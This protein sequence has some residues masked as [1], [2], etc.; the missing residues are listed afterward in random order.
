MSSKGPVGQ[1]VKLRGGCLPP[2]GRLTTGL[3]VGNL[4]HKSAN[5]HSSPKR[6]STPPQRRAANQVRVVID[7]K[8]TERSITH[9]KTL[10][11]IVLLL[12]LLAVSGFAQPTVTQ[13]QNAA[14]NALAPLP[15]SAIGQGSYFS[16]YGTGI[17]PSTIAYWNP[18]PLPTSLGELPL[19]SRLGQMPRSRLI[20]NSFRPVRSTRYC[21]QAPLRARV[22]S[23]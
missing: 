11:A 5:R 4:P 10:F 8:P 1:L 7:L 3:Q 17:G 9:V 14:S 12:G 6:L 20:P 21:L 2:R 22:P 23:R 13:V 15:N 19:L 18:Y 16:I